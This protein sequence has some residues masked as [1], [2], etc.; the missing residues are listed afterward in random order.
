MNKI[1]FAE[2]SRD[3]LVPVLLLSVVLLLGI[4]IGMNIS[5]EQKFVLEFKSTPKLPTP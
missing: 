2:P 1:H 4:I 3:R 5:R